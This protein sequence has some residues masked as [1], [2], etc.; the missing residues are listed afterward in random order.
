MD[1]TESKGLLYSAFNKD[2]F[3]LIPLGI[4]SVL[5]VGC[6]TGT[7]GNAIKQKFPW[8][9]TGGIT[10]SADEAKLAGLVYDRVFVHDLNDLSLDVGNDWDCIIFSL[11]LEHTYHPDQ[12]LRHYAT[13]LSKDGIIIIALPNVLFFKQRFEF[14]KGK[15]EYSD[16]GGFMDNTHFRFFD[17]NTAQQLPLTSGLQVVNARGQGFFPLGPLRSWFPSL[18]KRINDRMVAWLPGMFSFQFLIVA[19]KK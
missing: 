18:A 5:D 11:V 6:G 2:V 17:F 13:R 1:N 3:E 16:H 4:Q 9:K 10:F 19:K 8:A 7:L 14:L 12:V 15:F